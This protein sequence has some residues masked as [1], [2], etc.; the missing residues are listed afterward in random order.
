VTRRTASGPAPRATRSRLHTLRLERQAARLGRDLLDDKREAI[1]RTLLERGPRLAAARASAAE[2]LRRATAS[3]RE[4]QA[5]LGTR[6]VDAAVLAQPVVVSVDWRPGSV[7]GVP[8]PRLAGRVPRFAP[9]YGPAATSAGLDQAGADFSAA[10]AALVAFAEEDEAV[11]NLQSGLSRT[12]R[13][14]RALEEVVIPALEHEARAIAI[15]VEE[16]ERDDAVRHR[17]SGAFR[18]ASWPGVP[19]GTS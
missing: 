14:L 10:I 6:G 18:R 3:W 9:Q 4:A 13:R 17:Q 12:I 5:E 1:L 8:T 15:A 19:N 2:K 16:D 11:R 7:V